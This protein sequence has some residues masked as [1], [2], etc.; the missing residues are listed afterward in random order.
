MARMVAIVLAVSFFG[1]CRV[2]PPNALIGAA[3]SG[4]TEA[5]KTLVAAGADPNQRWGVNDW[6]PL[7]HAIHK[8]QKASVEALLAGGADVNGQSGK[9]ITALIMAAGYGYTDIVQMLL[10]H[11]ADPRAETPD[12][13]NALA[14]AVGGVPDI[15]K[16]TVGAC[17]T[18]TVRALLAKAPDLKLKDNFYGRAA[19]MAARAAGCSDVLALIDRGSRASGGLRSGR[20]HAAAC[21]IRIRPPFVSGRRERK[22]PEIRAAKD[23]ATRYLAPGQA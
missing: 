12:G 8:D 23:T 19:R 13:D 4:D 6:T 18:E 20:P 21:K 9:G 11:G 15:D 1:G 3:R 5:I 17:Q 10:N 2:E 14:A 22:S 16:F 7:M